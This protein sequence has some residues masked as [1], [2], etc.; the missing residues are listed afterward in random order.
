MSLLQQG[1]EASSGERQHFPFNTISPER[2]ERLLLQCRA[3][4]FLVD[5]VPDADAARMR[6]LALIPP[7]ADV[8]T[9]SSQTLV[10]IGFMKT[11]EA[12][13]GAGD[14]EGLRYYRS[15]MAHAGSSCV[16]RRR[17]PTTSWAASMR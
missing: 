13:A 4:G 8:T 1:G 15:R 7:K 17:P 14:T 6:L 9:G 5:L 3:R 2:L 11:C 12:E 10:Q 16:V